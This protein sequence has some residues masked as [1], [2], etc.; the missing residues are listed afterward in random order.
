MRSAATKIQFVFRLYGGLN[1]G[2][3]FQKL[4]GPT[5]VAGDGAGPGEFERAFT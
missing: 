1:F 4:C 5:R 3:V 2:M